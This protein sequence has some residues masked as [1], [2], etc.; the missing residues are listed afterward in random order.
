MSDFSVRSSRLRLD[1]VTRVLIFVHYVFQHVLTHVFLECHFTGLILILHV[2][3]YIS[4]SIL[5]R[6]P[7]LVYFSL[8]QLRS[9]ATIKN[10]LEVVCNWLFGLV[11]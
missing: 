7:G 9:F 6:S 8:G 1:F 3:I 4:P 2:P 5:H 11:V 10:C